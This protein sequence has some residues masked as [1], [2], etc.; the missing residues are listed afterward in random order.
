MGRELHEAI[1]ALIDGA[2]TPSQQWLAYRE[3]VRLQGMVYSLEK[4]AGKAEPDCY[5]Q[6]GRASKLSSSS[7]KTPS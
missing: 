1:L 2:A 4:I 6:R 3:I 7:E 5:Y